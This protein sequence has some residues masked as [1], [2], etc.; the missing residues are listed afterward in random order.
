[1]MKTVKISLIVPVYNTKSFLDDC[2]RSVLAQTFQDWELILVDD[3][4]TDG[5]GALCE[6]WAERDA[7]I[8]VLHQPNG[9]V[10]RAR[11]YGIR[12]ARGDYLVFLDSDDRILPAYLQRLWELKEE[13]KVPL[14]AV[15]FAGDRDGVSTLHKKLPR[16][17]METDEYLSCVL[18]DRYGLAL[19]CWAVIYPA[20]WGLAFQ[21]SIAYGED[22][23]FFCRALKKA[24]RIAY[25]SAP[26][27]LYTTNRDGNTYT[28]QSLKKTEEQLAVWEKMKDL[29]LDGNE[30]EEL[31][32]HFLRILCDVNLQAARQS[33]RE[34]KKNMKAA[35]RWKACRYFGALK[36][37]TTVS[38]RH[39][40]RLGLLL[41]SPVW[42]AAL[43]ER[44]RKGSG[45]GT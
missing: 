12:Q 31:R 17:L 43:W 20:A 7:R 38:P 18:S 36:G 2:I 27:Y 25:D 1:M 8:R 14:A 23:L 44:M 3:G 4:S 22:S 45:Y 29:F 42:G 28:V 9:G 10:S 30:P 19:T 26:L 32:G 34:N 33:A 5:S 21:E 41:L 6:A 39:K 40:L 35:H 24:G 15:G 16:P 37:N 11:N 13:Y